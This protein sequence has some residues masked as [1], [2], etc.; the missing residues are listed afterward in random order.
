MRYSTQ[1][2]PISDLK[3]NAADVLGELNAQRKPLIITQNGEAKAVLQDVAGCE[4]TQ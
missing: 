4:E 3:A 1:I 2:K